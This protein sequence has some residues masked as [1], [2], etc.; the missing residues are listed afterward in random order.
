MPE[1]P[2]GMQKLMQDVQINLGHARSVVGTQTSGKWFVSFTVGTDGQVRGVKVQS[3][4]QA[5]RF[6][7][8]VEVKASEEA[9]W[10]AVQVLQRKW[11]PGSQNGQ[12]V[13]VN[14]VLPIA[15]NC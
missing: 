5:S 1:Y 11:K 15:F 2:G 10:V 9:V 7:S 13:A 8:V 12:P 14:M 3:A 4:P 6:L